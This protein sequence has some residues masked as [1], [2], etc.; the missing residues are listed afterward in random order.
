M[1]VDAQLDQDQ[2]FDQEDLPCYSSRS[3][4]SKIV[5]LLL[6]T[7]SKIEALAHASKRTSLLMAWQNGHIAVVGG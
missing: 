7:G 5:E 2:F 6:V 4:H 1:S 3:G